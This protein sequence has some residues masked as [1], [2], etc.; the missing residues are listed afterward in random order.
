[1]LLRKLFSVPGF[2]IAQG[3]LCSASPL[4]TRL[5]LT[6][7]PDWSN[8]HNLHYH[9][10]SLCACVLAKSLQSCLTLCDPMDRSPPGSFVH[11][12]FPGKNTGVGCHALLQGI[13]PTQGLN[14]CLLMLL[15]CRQILHCW[16]T[17]EAYN[18]HFRK[19]QIWAKLF[20]FGQCHTDVGKED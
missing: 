7:C 16:A 13:F 1:M 8:F 6:K 14:P 3:K 19:Q 20:R 17:R 18:R 2:T 5:W 10:L 12:D 4:T 11:G 15:R 9:H